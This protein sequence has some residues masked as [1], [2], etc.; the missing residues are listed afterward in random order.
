MRDDPDGGDVAVA[1]DAVDPVGYA[2]FDGEDQ[3]GASVGVTQP[4]VAEREG[5]IDQSETDGD[6]LAER[7]A[8]DHGE[9]PQPVGGEVVALSEQGA[10][11]LDRTEPVGECGEHRQFLLGGDR[12]DDVVAVD[13]GG[14]QHLLFA[15]PVLGREVQEQPRSRRRPQHRP[16]GVVG[17]AG[18]GGQL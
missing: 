5:E 3:C 6:G 14:G 7:R 10:E 13:P 8:A 9:A 17:G 18:H 16:G 4:D 11:A 1:D 12:T 15:D 2:V